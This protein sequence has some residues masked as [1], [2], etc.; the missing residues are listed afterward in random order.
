MVD[1]PIPITHF[2]WGG[3]NRPAA[4]A[5]VQGSPEAITFQLWCFEENPII[6]CIEPNSMVCLDSCLE[7]FLNPFPALSKDYLNFEMNAAGTLL[8]Q[9]GPDREHRHFVSLET[10]G[11]PRVQACRM[12]EMWGVEL[13]VPLSF[14]R[15]LYGPDAPARLENPIGNF[16]QCSGPP[17]E[18]YGCWKIPNTL[19][20]D[21]H[22]P[23]SFVNIPSL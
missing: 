5:R 14:L 21:F 4:F 10:S 13:N 6:T 16:Y 17:A 9:M 15:T 22:R 23:E 3:R 19:K 2:P 12:P 8:L 20:P 7:V 18:R 11:Y 1:I